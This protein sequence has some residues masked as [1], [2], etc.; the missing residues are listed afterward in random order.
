MAIDDAIVDRPHADHN[1][2]SAKIWL[3]CDLHYQFKKE[4]SDEWDQPSAASIRGTQMHDIAEYAVAR[5]LANE[6]RHGWNA[7]DIEGAVEEAC[8]HVDN[9]LT[10]DDLGYVVQAVTQVILLIDQCVDPEIHLE[11]EVPI[12]HEPGAVGYVDVVIIDETRVYVVD[13]KMGRTPVDHRR[14]EQLTG[15]CV[16]V[17]QALHEQG[18][19]VSKLLFVNG[20]MQPMLQDEILWDSGIFL[21]ELQTF[22]TVASHRVDVQRSGRNLMLP[23]DPSTCG[24]CPAK[25]LGI[26]GHHTSLMTSLIADV[27]SPKLSPKRVEQLVRNEKEIVDFIKNLKQEIIEDETTYPEWKRIQVKNPP[28]WRLEKEDLEEVLAKEGVDPYVVG[29]PTQV[30]QANPGSE[31]LIESL[32]KEQGHHVRLKWTGEK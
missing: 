25:R 17:A 10:R 4:Y 1:W 15:Y 26:C 31:E 24:W 32:C 7:F 14:N 22:Q 3:N 6:R 5:L 9:G 2:S 20:I 8:E 11:L 27:G 21:K 30:R 18:R 13:Y 12:V 23:S 19:D 28:R 16:G 29:S